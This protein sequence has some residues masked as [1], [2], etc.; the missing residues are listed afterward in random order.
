MIKHLTK[1]ITSKFLAYAL[2]ISIVPLLFFGIFILQGFNQIL[3]DEIDKYHSDV[4]TEKKI[5]IEQTISDVE[6]LIANLSGLQAIK[7]TLV[8]DVKRDSAYYKLTTQANM[9]YILSGYTNL[10]GLVAI[11]IFSNNNEQYHVGETLDIS[12]TNIQLKDKLYREAEKS[13]SRIYWS[14]IEENI[15]QNSKYKYVIN[16]VKLIYATGEETSRQPIG[17]LIISY[18][19][20]YFEDS[21][22]HLHG[23]GYFII[24]DRKNHIIYHPQDEYIGQKLSQGIT[25]KFT[26]EQGSFIQPINGEEQLVNFEKTRF[27]DCIV[28]SI[29]PLKAIYKKIAYMTTVLIILLLVCVLMAGSFALFVSRKI[30]FPIKRVTDTFKALQDGNIHEDKRL[31]IKSEDEIGQ[32]GKLFNSFIDAKKDILVQKALEKEL[33][34]RNAELQVTLT[35]LQET[36][37]QLI[38]QE[39]LA[40]IGQLAAGVAHEINNPLGFTSSNFQTL[41]KYVIAYNEIINVYMKIEKELLLFGDPKINEICA[42]ATK[43]CKKLKIDYINEDINEILTDTDDGLA[44]ISG[45]VVSMKNFSRIDQLGEQTEYSINE[46]IRNTLIVANNE[47]KYHADVECKLNETPNIIGNGGQLNQ[48]FL[49]L[50]IN[51]VYAIKE[52]HKSA[53]GLIKIATYQEEDYIV[54]TIE[55]N[56]TGISAKIKDKIFLPF[57][58]TKPVGEGTGLGLGIAYDIIINKHKGK[59]ELE[60]EEGQGVKFIIKLPAPKEPSNLN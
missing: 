35:K 27:G 1:S 21:F 32:L 28:A 18:D 43:L 10:K 36:Q 48:V 19:V 49:N 42:E 5:F 52:R 59:I 54:C 3:K 39:K 50:I 9:G 38:Q 24:V 57:F 46:G 25:D 11:D 6:S 13:K 15:N 12:K 26:G 30:V 41:K 55:D 33:N 4:V 51:A 17:A 47:I 34:T 22:K 29:I 53:K 31:E 7:D 60:S 58:T 14:G 2:L 44:R 56:G 37:G 45:I 20:N 23:D 40:G 8:V 16:A